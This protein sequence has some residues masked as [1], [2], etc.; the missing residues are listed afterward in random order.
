MPLREKTL[1]RLLYESA[2]R[3]DSVLSLDIEDLDKFLSVGSDRCW[4]GSA[5]AWSPPAS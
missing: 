1:W 2:A 5:A 3:A 4:R